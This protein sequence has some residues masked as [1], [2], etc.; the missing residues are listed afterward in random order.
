MLRH[1]YAPV[2][3]ANNGPSG[4]VFMFFVQKKDTYVNSMSIFPN[5]SAY[6]ADR[7]LSKRLEFKGEIIYGTCKP[8]YVGLTYNISEGGIGIKAKNL[9]IPKTR[10]VGDL[11]LG[12]ETLKLQGVI[13]WSDSSLKGYQSKMG[14]KITSRPKKIRII[15]AKLPAI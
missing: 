13:K 6:M 15:Y 2:T 1:F 8:V 3:R 5:T 10:I 14:V 11:F 4:E 7:R 9:L 12:K